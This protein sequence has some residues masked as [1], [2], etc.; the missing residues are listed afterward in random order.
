MM[1][2]WATC[3]AQAKDALL[4]FRLGDFYEAFHDDALII[5]KEMQLT[6]TERNQV[7]MCGVPYHT[8]DMY[9][10]RLIQKG[11][12]I[13]I[14][15]QTED[16]Q[17]A[18]GLV[19]REIVQIITPATHFQS[20]T[21]KDKQNQFFVSIDAEKPA[22]GLAVIDLTTGQF[23]AS[24]LPSE[25]AVID[26]LCRLAPKEILTTS[27][28]SQQ[29]P[30][31]FQKLSQ[32]ITYLCNERQGIDTASSQLVL[33]KHCPEANL[34]LHSPLALRAAASLLCYLR[35]ELS[36][37]LSFL[38]TLEASHLDN[39]MRIDRSTLFHL[40]LV[41][42]ATGHSLYET[43]DRTATPMGGRL[44]RQWL[45]HPSCQIQELEQRQETI[46]KLIHHPNELHQARKSLETIRDLE[47]LLNR[48][49]RRKLQP[50]ELFSLAHSL[51]GVRA[52]ETALSPLS[53]FQTSSV[54][55]L[56][57]LIQSIFETLHNPPPSKLGDQET[58]QSKAHPE[59]QALR[60]ESRHVVNWIAQYQERL[61]QETK[62]KTLKVGY[63][64]AFGYYIEVSRGQAHLA[65]SWLH[66]TQT[67][68]NH[69]RF[70][71]EELAA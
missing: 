53:L 12:K 15:E 25:E 31:F 21:L 45:L 9:I 71:S 26:E 41:D 60:E 8:A 4:L 46:R 44:L 34:H 19:R 57:P 43:L 52:L 54:H 18:K 69:E 6:L 24:S 16:P 33:L 1:L 62:M 2:Q 22:W 30:L 49:L 13:A 47:R 64:K 38:T 42:S 28:L 50:K 65:P 10:D 63:T 36:L 48:A 56:A 61:R 51:A 68:V 58:I 3:K 29:E 66:K 37:D 55:K 5:A 35:E 20:S 67:L 17:T 7:P 32:Y 27:V 14:A 11:F 59:L 39:T 23:W 70:T 40:E